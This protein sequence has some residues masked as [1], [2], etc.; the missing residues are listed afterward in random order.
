MCFGRQKIFRCEPQAIPVSLYALSTHHQIVCWGSRSRTHTQHLH[1][2]WFK[3][4]GFK[5]PA[6]IGIAGRFPGINAWYARLNREQRTRERGTYLSA[7]HETHACDMCIEHVVCVCKHVVTYGDRRSRPIHPIIWMLKT[8]P[9]S[10]GYP[11]FMKYP[12]VYQYIHLIA[13]TQLY[14]ALTVHIGWG[15]RVAKSTISLNCL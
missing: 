8:K 15:I 4:V 2:G 5:R 13:H 3:F 7:K 14:H 1:T 12:Y 6:S 11:C 9:V 10:S